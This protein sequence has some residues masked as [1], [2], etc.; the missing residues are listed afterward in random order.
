MRNICGKFDECTPIPYLVN[1]VTSRCRPRK[2][3]NGIFN[4]LLYLPHQIPPELLITLANLSV[5]LHV[6]CRVPAFGYESHIC[7]QHLEKVLNFVLRT[8]TGRY[9]LGRTLGVRKKGRKGKV[10][11]SHRGGKGHSRGKV[12]RGWGRGVKHWIW[13]RPGRKAG[14][15]PEGTV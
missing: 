4:Q 6:P 5:L 7:M 14:A 12:W 15:R 10:K 2:K 3:C 9:E 11:V 8:D 13:W 1:S